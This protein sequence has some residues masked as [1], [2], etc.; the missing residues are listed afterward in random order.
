MYTVYGFCDERFEYSTPS[1]T[2]VSSANGI[3]VHMLRLDQFQG[4]LQDLVSHFQLQC[5]TQDLR[6]PADEMELFRLVCIHIIP[7]NRKSSN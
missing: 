6:T 7:S 3:P 5:D 2:G 4:Q 1:P